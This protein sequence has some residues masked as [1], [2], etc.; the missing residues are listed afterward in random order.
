MKDYTIHRRI[1]SHEQEK[2]WI[3]PFHRSYKSNSRTLTNQTE[4]AEQRL[5]NFKAY[6]DWCIILQC[7][8]N[9]SP[10]TFLFMEANTTVFYININI[11][12]I[13]NIIIDRSMKRLNNPKYASTIHMNWIQYKCTECTECPHSHDI[14]ISNQ[15]Q[16]QNGT[17][18][19]EYFEDLKW[20]E[21]V[22]NWWRK[23]LKWLKL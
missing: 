15:F 2:F 12:V 9:E 23:W 16:R 13:I 22:E 4:I 10:A 14:R 3:D 19:N 5:N 1:S 6:S 7:L 17:I 8:H 11:F 21:N 20:K 18:T